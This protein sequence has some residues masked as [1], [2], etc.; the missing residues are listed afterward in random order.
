[1]NNLKSPP[2]NRAVNL[3]RIYRYLIYGAEVRELKE[4]QALETETCAI[5][6]FTDPPGAQDVHE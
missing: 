6:A 3:A 1:M 5:F 2:T 4:L